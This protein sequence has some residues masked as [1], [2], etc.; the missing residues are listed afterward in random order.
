MEDFFKNILGK[1]EKFTEADLESAGNEY[2]AATKQL[3]TVTFGNVNFDELDT[4][5]KIAR[6][7]E[8]RNK[9]EKIHK[10][11][12]PEKYEN[13]DKNTVIAHLP[14]VILTEEAEDLATYGALA[15]KE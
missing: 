12:N 9:F 3:N 4:G 15:E 14:P 13:G 2:V 7:N 1:K 10:S 11:L 8:A 6:Y 5:K